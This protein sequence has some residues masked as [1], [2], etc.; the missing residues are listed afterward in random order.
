MFPDH[1]S[2]EPFLPVY[3]GK[4][5]NLAA[6]FH[7]DSDENLIALY[8]NGTSSGSLEN[9]FHEYTHLLLRHNALFWPLWLNEGMAEFTR[10]SM[11][12]RIRRKKLLDGDFE[13]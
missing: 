2:M 13:T 1:T 5:A 8:V 3:Q 7:R 4:A 12:L 11:D 6:F 9:V 10:R